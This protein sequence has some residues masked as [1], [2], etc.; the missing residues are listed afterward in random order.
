MKIPE[1][2]ATASGL[3]FRE[4]SRPRPSVSKYRTH[5][6]RLGLVHLSQELKLLNTVLSSPKMFV[7][8]MRLAHRTWCLWVLW[9]RGA[10][11][12]P[13]LTSCKVGE[14][15]FSTRRT[16]EETRGKQGMKCTPE[17]GLAKPA[18]EEGGPGQRKDGARKRTRTPQDQCVQPPASRQRVSSSSQE[19]R[20]PSY[21]QIPG[22]TAPRLHILL[23]S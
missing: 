14:L 12:S 13:S 15:S 3:D 11:S 7:L 16:L 6:V 21:L 10:F 2:M 4:N 18:R 19:V 22:W 5:H 1:A 9:A 23:M 8:K 20:P 17:T